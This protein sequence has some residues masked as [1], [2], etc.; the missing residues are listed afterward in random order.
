MNTCVFVL[1]RGHRHE[2]TF[3]LLSG[4]ACTW[5]C[6]HSL[7]CSACVE[8]KPPSS[9]KHAPFSPSPDWGYYCP[10][11]G[12]CTLEAGLKSGWVGKGKDTARVV[13]CQDLH[14]R[15]DEDTLHAGAT[16]A[17]KEP[18]GPCAVPRHQKCTPV[19]TGALNLEEWVVFPEMK[20]PW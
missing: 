15:Q 5:M 6:T 2:H 20:L 16:E 17:P 4:Y 19:Q 7:P 18:W 10:A 9:T 13:C 11:L 3:V 12:A 14:T 1:L 8:P